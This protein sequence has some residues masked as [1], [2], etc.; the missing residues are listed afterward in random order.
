[1]SNLRT[2][3]YNTV[4]QHFEQDP[5]YYEFCTYTLRLD[6]VF[7]HW[8]KYGAVRKYVLVLMGALQE[9]SHNK[10]YGKHG[11]V[12]ACFNKGVVWKAG[13]I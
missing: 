2:F 6:K 8:K 3:N 10:T 12:H 7:Y 4:L 9:C 1:M 11:L 5:I 13:L